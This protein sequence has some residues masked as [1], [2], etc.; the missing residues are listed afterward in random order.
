ME[1]LGRL[2]CFQSQAQKTKETFHSKLPSNDHIA[3]L[4]SWA[5]DP[6]A[7][8]KVEPNRAPDFSLP[9]HTC[10][11]FTHIQ[12]Q[13]TYKNRKKKNVKRYFQKIRGNA[14]FT[15]A[16]FCSCFYLFHFITQWLYIQLLFPKTTALPTSTTHLYDPLRLE[17]ILDE[18]YD[19]LSELSPHVLC[20]EGTIFL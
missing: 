17:T 2:S 20:F 1:V 6:A 7:V 5:K 10:K 18:D 3:V 11:I 13:T 12:I 16:L 4:Y 15:T 14:V 8:S 19:L 9:P